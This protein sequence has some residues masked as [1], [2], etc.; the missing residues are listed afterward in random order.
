MVRDVRTSSCQTLRPRKSTGSL[1]GDAGDEL[2]GM[3]PKSAANAFPLRSVR[4]DIVAKRCEATAAFLLT[5][6]LPATAAWA[7]ECYAAPQSPH[8]Q[9]RS[10]LRRRQRRG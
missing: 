6:P 3:H 2:I 5:T 8:Q 7:W 10:C 4:S 1:A 9:T